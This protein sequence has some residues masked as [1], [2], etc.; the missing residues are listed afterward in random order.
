MGESATAGFPMPVITGAYP[1]DSAHGHSGD[2]KITRFGHSCVL[3]E[4]GGAR[5]LI[6]P[7]VYSRGWE[8]IATPDAVFITHRHADHADPV[9]LP[10]YLAD[11]P[12]LPCYVEPG[13]NEQLIVPT[14]TAMASGQQI[15][16]GQLTVTVVGGL[17]AVIHPDIPRVGNFGLVLR[18]LGEPSVFHPGDALDVTPDDID[19]LCVPMMA[20]WEKVSQTIDFVRGV[21]PRQMIPIHDGLLNDDGFWMI[22]GHLSA[23][24]TAQFVPVRDPRP[25]TVTRGI[26]L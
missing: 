7:G 23:R 14:T 3:V 13:V 10:A 17:H 25:W 12:D 24:T 8:S 16:L 6:D 1:W 4:A 5:V 9:R 22:A 18:A 2:M 26:T 21:V 15:T 20:P 11:R 19:V